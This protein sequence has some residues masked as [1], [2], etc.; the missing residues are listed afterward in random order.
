MKIGAVS[1]IR[2]QTE[3]QVGA[4]ANAADNTKVKNIQTQ[5][6]QA[7]QKLKDVSYD[8]KMT[9]EEKS[10]RRQEIQKELSVG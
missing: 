9:S 10:K 7:Q 1:D 6:E 5:I 2:M 4:K 8:E 3:N